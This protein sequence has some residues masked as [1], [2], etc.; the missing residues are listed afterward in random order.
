VV[1]RLSVEQ[2]SVTNIRN[3]Q[4][5]TIDTA[6]DVIVLAGQNGSGKT[7]VLEALYLLCTSKS[8]RASRPAESIAHG[9][10]EAL[11][12]GKLLDG[13]V[14]REQR[15]LLKEGGRSA[16]FDD[17]RPPSL[18]AYALASPVVI[19][20]PGELPLTMGPAQERRKF[21]D[22]VAFYTT[23]K[24]TKALDDYTR[25]QRT[26]QKLLES[27]G[28]DAPGIDPWEAMVARHGLELM[29]ARHHAAERVVEA[30]EGSFVQFAA[31]QLV[32]SGR[33]V[34]TAPD[35]EE[36]YLT[37]LQN[38]RAGDLHRGSARIGP[39]RD[40]LELTLDG[41]PL[42]QVGSQG[43]HRAAVLALK[44]AEIAAIER[45]R[46]ARPVLL[47]DDVSS[48]LDADRLRAFFSF[49]QR[50]EGQVFLTTTRP[51]WIETDTFGGGSSRRDF[52]VDRGVL[53]R[54]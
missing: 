17:K 53:T 40:D 41:Q 34:A 1:R 32:L 19:F 45:A 27:R 35:D 47:L 21:L 43:Q 18:A 33:Y 29:H 24:G 42:R 8:F 7:S 51:E 28:I 3:L 49:L 14:L 26:R 10:T 36:S 15:L 4:S 37:M 20:H 44:I 6:A 23:P 5:A 31:P 48:E 9:Q 46:G 39:H 2:L 54:L 12:R 25:A 52:E 11:V 22:R 16:R 38:S 30:M 13:E 50:E